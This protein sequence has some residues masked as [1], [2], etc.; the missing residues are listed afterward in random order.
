MFVCCELLI[1]S[2]KACYFLEV[3]H[4]TIR[5]SRKNAL[6]LYCFL[7]LRGAK[8]MLVQALDFLIQLTPF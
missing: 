5:H 8:R 3:F 7:T 4:Y 1:F 6:Q 2:M